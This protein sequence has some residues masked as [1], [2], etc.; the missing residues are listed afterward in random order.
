LEPSIQADSSR[1][2]LPL[3]IKTSSADET[4]ALGERLAL[5]L[6]KGSVIALKGP[7]GAGKT[8]LTKG[9]A[10]GLG[11]TEEVTSPTY[12]I[13]SEYQAVIS[14]E[15]IPVY[16]IDAYR[17]R[18]NDDFTAIGGEEL[19]FGEGISIVEWSELIY[20]SIPAEAIRVDFELIGENERRIHVY[21]DKQ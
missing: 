21:K 16:H 10:N 11:I 18:G 6:S 8:C 19:I 17:L 1:I 9:I 15:K 7:L 4:F 20:G 3:L 12:T 5:L 2:N 13:V 14:G